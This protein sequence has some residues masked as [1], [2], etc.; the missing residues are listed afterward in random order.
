MQDDTSMSEG[1]VCIPNIGP[2]ERRRRF[3]FGA[4]TLGAGL[5]GAPSS[6]F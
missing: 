6:W 5:L 4:V 2:A 3:R 1:D